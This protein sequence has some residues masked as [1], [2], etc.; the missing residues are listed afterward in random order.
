MENKSADEELDDDK[1]KEDLETDKDSVPLT[2]P[3]K[4]EKPKRKPGRPAGINHVQVKTKEVVQRAA[5]RYMTPI[6]LLLRQME[7]AEER[8]VKSWEKFEKA[9]CED[10][11]AAKAVEHESRA[12]K[13][14]EKARELALDAAPFIHPKMPVAIIT[15]ASGVEGQGLL[16]DDETIVEKYLNAG[17]INA[18][19]S[20][21][22]RDCTPEPV[23]DGSGREDVGTRASEE[24]SSSL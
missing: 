21:P 23:T 5:M 24:S 6:D 20:P 3:P 14:D 12:R 10:M 13:D 22:A 9:L 18:T 1:K 4:K 17:N 15:H 19:I 16:Q 8:S 2:P 7:R 11:D